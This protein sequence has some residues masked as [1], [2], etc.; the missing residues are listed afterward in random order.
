MI[1][2]STGLLG[3]A[4][5]EQFPNAICLNSKSGDLTNQVAVKNIVSTKPDI[6]IHCAAKVSGITENIEKPAEH[7]YDNV[8]MNTMLMHEAHKAG[9]KRFINILSTCAYPDDETLCPYKEE[10][11]LKGLP[12]PTNFAYGMAKR[13]AY[14][15]TLAYNAQYGTNYQCLIPCNLFGPGEK[16]DDRAHF[17]GASIRKIYEAKKDGS[18]EIKLLGTGLPLRQFAFASDFARFIKLCIDNDITETLN[19]A[20]D[21]N[22]SIKEIAC[23]ALVACGASDML[24]SFSDASMNGQMRKDASNKRMMELFPD[25]KFTPLHEGI[26]IAYQHYANEQTN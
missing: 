5:Q 21:E 17:L 14:V 25:F 20:P 9:V 12:T 15:Q 4:L 24:I 3:I 19:F 7:Y 11:I 2:G 18:N 16:H 22:Y 6:I 8:M 23:M 26:K 1:T 10:D 13:M